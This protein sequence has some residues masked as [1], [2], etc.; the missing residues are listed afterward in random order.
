VRGRIEEKGKGDY[1]RDACEG[2]SGRRGGEAA[3]RMQSE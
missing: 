2:G 1:E 3:I